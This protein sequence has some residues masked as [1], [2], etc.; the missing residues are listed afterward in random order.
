LCRKANALGS[1]IL[2]LHYIEDS[3]EPAV[4]AVPSAAGNREWAKIQSSSLFPACG[5]NPLK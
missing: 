1:G 3:L 2:S 5:S 4:A